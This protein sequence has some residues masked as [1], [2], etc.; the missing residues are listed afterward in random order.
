MGLPL[1]NLHST[2]TAPA[3]PPPPALHVQHLPAQQRFVASV[4]GGTCVADYH[5]VD[6]TAHIVHTEVPAA[7]QGQGLAARLVADVLVQMRALGWRVRPVCS[8]VRAYM[9]RH[10]ETHDLLEP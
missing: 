5:L 10:P 6:G 2:M 3:H 4:P 8:Y 7:L 1:H 9:R